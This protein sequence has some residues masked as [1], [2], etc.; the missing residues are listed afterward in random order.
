MVGGVTPVP[1]QARAYQGRRAG[2]VSRLAA[3]VIDAAVVAAVL[4]VG[5]AA[6]VGLSLMLDPRAFT[7]PRPSI[8]FNVAV[9]FAVTV[10]YLTLAWGLVGRS[11]GKVVMG[12]RVLGPRGRRLRL[13]GALLRAIACTVFPIGLLWCAVSPDSRSLQD[14]LL[15]TSVVY[16]W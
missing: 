13:P 8:A 14:L 3:A 5:Y 4:A 9:A 1:R 2:V 7:F 12:L 10:V 11:Y 6:I 15:R 16:S